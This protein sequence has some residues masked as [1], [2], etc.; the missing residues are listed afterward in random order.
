[1]RHTHIKREFV[2]M[3]RYNIFLNKNYKNQNNKIT[4]HH[5]TGQD[6]SKP[7]MAQ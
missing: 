2:S 6:N 4:V 5:S 3:V 7:Y 1:M